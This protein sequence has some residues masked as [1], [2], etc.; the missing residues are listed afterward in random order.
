MTFPPD[1]PKRKNRPSRVRPP[2]VVQTRG[3]RDPRKDA[4]EVAATRGA[5]LAL[6]R[7][8]LYLLSLIHI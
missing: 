1:H 3:S 5:R 7:V 6:F 4:L 8:V 2:P